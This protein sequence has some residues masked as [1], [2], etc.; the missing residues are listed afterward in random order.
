ME[1]PT[2]NALLRRYQDGHAAVVEALAAITPAELDARPAPDDWTAREVVHHL[3]DSEMTSAIRLRRLLAED[4]PEI[5]GYD[6]DRFRRKL[7][8]DT[9]PIEASLEAFRLARVTTAQILEGAAPEDWLRAG[10]HS[11]SGRYSV[12]T[13]LEIYS[14]HAIDHADQIRRARD[15]NHRFGDTTLGGPVDL[16]VN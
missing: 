2:R 8:Y 5:V 6:E 13:W 9:R 3:A 1:L 12:E 11:E 15:L 10:T 4:N 14:Q 7:R 16:I